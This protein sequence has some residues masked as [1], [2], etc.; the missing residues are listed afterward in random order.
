MSR[1]QFSTLQTI[2]DHAVSGWLNARASSISRNVQ[3]VAAVVA[4][5]RIAV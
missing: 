1:G 3:V 4:A 5:L 2:G